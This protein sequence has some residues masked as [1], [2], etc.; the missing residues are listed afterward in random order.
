MRAHPAPDPTP[1]RPRMDEGAPQGSHCPLPVVPASWGSEPH[2]KLVFKVSCLQSIASHQG[3]VP[4]HLA[5]YPLLPTTPPT[6][7]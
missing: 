1:D 4:D 5:S 6:A 3:L 7:T 2:S